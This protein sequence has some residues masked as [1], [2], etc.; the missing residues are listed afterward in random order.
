[1]ELTREEVNKVAVAIASAYWRFSYYDFL[2]AALFRDDEYANDKW[3]S[4]QTL[5]HSI[6]AFDAT[7]LTVILN[8]TPDPLVS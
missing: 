6:N 8:F 1:M 7:T 2:A 5:A 4:F 3:K